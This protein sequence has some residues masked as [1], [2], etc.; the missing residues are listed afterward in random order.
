[1]PAHK[2]RY[3]ILILFLLFALILG[4]WS[5]RFYLAELVIT[6][7][8]QASGLENVTVNIHQ[9]DQNQSQL[10]RFGFTLSTATGLL[11]FDALDTSINYNPEQLADGRVNSIV[12]NN[13]QLHYQNTAKIQA[14]IQVE[15][16]AESAAAPAM[17]QNTLQPLKIITA[18]RSAL[19]KYLIVETLFIRHIT[20]N[21]EVFDELQCK[22]LQLKSTTRNET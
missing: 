7:S 16:A 5:V 13:L 12:I 20:L 1:M 18:F 9:L 11:Q 15:S 3:L 22:N 6:S 4:I 21:G 14:E 10:P 2:L 17:L 8:M 19:R